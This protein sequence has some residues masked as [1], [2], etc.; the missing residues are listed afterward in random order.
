MAEVDQILPND[1]VDAPTIP[2]ADIKARKRAISRGKVTFAIGGAFVLFAMWV[3]LNGLG[4]GIEDAPSTV[5]TAPTE[6]NQIGGEMTP[7]YL[8]SMENANNMIDQRAREAGV[9]SLPTPVDPVRVAVRE[10]DV[11]EEVE[12]PAP[13]PVRVDIPDVEIA[14]APRMERAEPVRVAVPEETATVR[15]V[16][17]DKS[18]EEKPENPYIALMAANM[19]A[20]SEAQKPSGLQSFEI[21]TV[22][23][24]GA[25]AANRSGDA[26]RTEPE[27]GPAAETATPRV[28]GAGT[29]FDEPVTVEEELAAA[30]AA[31]AEAGA[32]VSGEEVMSALSG[33]RQ[34]GPAPVSDA[35]LPEEDRGELLLPAGSVSYAENLMSITSDR[36]TPVVAR[37][38]SGPMAGNVLRGAYGVDKASGKMSV[39]FTSMSDEKGK[40]VPVEAIAVDGFTAETV[41]RSSIDR[42][43]LRRYA[44]VLGATFITGLAA[45]A[46]EPD[47]TIITNSDGDQ[48]V[49]EQARTTEQAAYAGLAAS[50]DAISAD[51]LE[52]SPKGPEIK[53]AAGFPL[54]I[55]FV[56]DVYD[57]KK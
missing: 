48:E 32:P 6:S 1:T 38:V 4:G 35:N 41:T 30:E 22:R 55:I 40:T 44:P 21:A 19:Q 36:E 45:A 57:E 31:A 53:I 3:A 28:G 47:K 2:A 18:A 23:D 51:L 11:V 16:E 10:Q 52:Y 24:A 49:V 43:L 25:D 20:I 8:R 39:N 26:G 9:S 42:R 17:Q 5:A 7:D 33:G 37:L 46:A 29:V 13:E 54:G 50:A 12:V 34:P 15:V 56:T 27:P 14:P